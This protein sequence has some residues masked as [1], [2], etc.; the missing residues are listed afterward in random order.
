MS[1]KYIDVDAFTNVLKGHIADL[2]R[3]CGNDS[4]EEK[5]LAAVIDEMN[6]FPTADVQEVKHAK[7]IQNSCHDRF[8]TCSECGRHVET[9][10][11]SPVKAY[12]YCNC[13]AKMDEEK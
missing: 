3:I 7:W 2:N 13:G 8:Y 6:A 5:T 4:D 9:Y 1:K 12:P 11:I 10:F